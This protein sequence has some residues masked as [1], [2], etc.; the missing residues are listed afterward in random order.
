[1][2]LF[3]IF[4]II[5]RQMMK[6]FNMIPNF[7]YNIKNNHLPQVFIYKIFQKNILDNS[8]EKNELIRFMKFELF[9]VFIFNI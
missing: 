4:S 9:I 2:S 5:L 3:L 7:F 8:K 1:M 6:L